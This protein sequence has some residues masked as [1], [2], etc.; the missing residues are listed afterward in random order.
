MAYSTERLHA[1]LLQPPADCT[2]VESDRATDSE[3]GQLTGACPAQQG[4]RGDAQVLTELFGGHGT[5]AREDDAG[6]GVHVTWHG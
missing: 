2:A 4:H 3:A 1:M 6:K 5:L